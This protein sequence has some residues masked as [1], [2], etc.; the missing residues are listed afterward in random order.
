FPFIA[1]E[2]FTCEIE[3]I[4]KTLVEDEELM[5]LL[6]S[7]LEAKETH[8]SLLA[9]YFSKVVIC[10]LV[11]KTIPF[12]QFIKDHQEILKQLVDLIGITSIMEV[13]KRL[14]GTDE[15]LYSSYTS[16]MQ[17]VE[18]TDILEMIVDK[19]GSS[20]C[21]EVHANAAEVL[22][23]V[24]RY[25]PPGL[26]TKLS[27]PS[28]TGRLLK[29]TLEDSR[30]KSVLVNSLSVCISLLDPKRFTLGTYHIYSRQLTH[31]SMVP[32][33]ETVEGMLYSLGGQI[34]YGC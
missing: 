22:C 21:P 16:A 26:A 10:L 7:F 31:G 8:N 4:L 32:N 30:P 23:T 24:A 20:D 27:S 5:L 29:H 12:M 6:F 15:H 2:I 28:C 25:A 14:V 13:L 19:F 9:G 17:W 33:P 3:M 18:D 1:C 11:R 34:Q